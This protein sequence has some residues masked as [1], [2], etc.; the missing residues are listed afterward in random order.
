[1]I[2]VLLGPPGVGKGTQGVLLCEAEGLRH[3]STGDLLRHARRDGTPL[4]LEAQA[5]MVRGELVPD[6]VIIGLVRQELE[7][8]ACEPGVVFDGFP[9]T[10]LQAEAL[11]QA[12]GELGG[13]VDRVIVL[14]ADEETLVK[15]L[16][17]R[18][19]C[20]ECDAVFNVYFQPSRVAEVCDRCGD[21][22]VRRGDDAPDTVRHRLEIYRELTEPLVRYY[23]SRGTSIRTVD[24][25][26]PVEQ[27]SH[28]MREALDR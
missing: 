11:D 9:R 28:A 14:R 1:V 17:G 2:V 21:E 3:V 5:F 7:S 27:V 12:L 24:G 10:V 4:G 23:E 13:A 18:R 15:R 25:D 26:A 8:G 16:S 22:L 20:T 6:D 19:S